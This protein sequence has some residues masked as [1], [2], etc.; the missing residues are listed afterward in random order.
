MF[1]HWKLVE[2]ECGNS[3]SFMAIKLLMFLSQ[4]MFEKMDLQSKFLK[5]IAP[6]LCLVSILTMGDN[7]SATES[8]RPIFS[9]NYCTNTCCKQAILN[10]C[11]LH[12]E[13][14]ITIEATFFNLY[15]DAK[16]NNTFNA[17]TYSVRSSSGKARVQQSTIYPE[18]LSAKPYSSFSL[19]S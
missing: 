18:L 17:S 4:T 3:H 10:S 7:Y 6:I 19:L 5:N 13:F 2:R 1:T 14:V 12:N 9:C 11:R 8:K 15:V 16:S